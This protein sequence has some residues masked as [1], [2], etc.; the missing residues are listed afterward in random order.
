MHVSCLPLH[1]L[2]FRGKK[3]GPEF[4]FFFGNSPKAPSIRI[5]S[6]APRCGGIRVEMERDVSPPGLPRPV[7][8]CPRHFAPLCPPTLVGPWD[9]PSFDLPHA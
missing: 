2:L 5:I 1:R 7:G 4:C 9:R 3:S 6:P 8:A